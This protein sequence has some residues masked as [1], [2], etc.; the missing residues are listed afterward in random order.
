MKICHHKANHHTITVDDMI[1]YEI[2]LFKKKGNWTSQLPF[3]LR[4]KKF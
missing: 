2:F 4:A 1:T 3:S